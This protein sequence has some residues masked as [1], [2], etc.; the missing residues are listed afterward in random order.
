MMEPNI[1][2]TIEQLV[3]HGFS[4]GDRHRIGTAIQQ[5]LARLLAEQ[6]VPPGVAQ[7]KTIGKLDGGAFEM[8]AGTPPRVIG[9]QIAQ[10]IYG[11]LQYEP[12]NAIAGEPASQD[13]VYPDA[14]ES[15]PA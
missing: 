3:L 6:G 5:E 11:G 13:I 8:K 4:P 1:E 15:P 2:L 12:A 9:A 14:V 7:G 10:A